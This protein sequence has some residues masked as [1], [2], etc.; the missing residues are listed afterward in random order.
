M[1]A[2]ILGLGLFASVGAHAADLAVRAVPVPL[3]LFSWT[4]FYVG[5]Q[6]G[7]ATLRDRLVETDVCVP[8]CIDSATGNPSGVIGGAHA[9]FNWQSGAIV[10][11]IEADIEG[12]SLSHTTIY[13][14]S[15]PDT[16]GSSIP[17][18]GS[19]RGRIGYAFNQVLIYATGGAAIAD[20][21]H[22]YFEAV[23]GATQTLSTTR[24]GWTIGGGIEYSLAQHWSARVEYRYSDFG[25]RTDA[26]A[27]VFPARFRENHSETENAVRIGVSYHF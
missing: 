26:P 15:A 17:V 11:G 14:L 2:V 5:G 25:H 24:T 23:A 9:G 10:F 22:R 20:I 1:R 4:G 16:F 27:I 21:E 7:G 12:A 3:P 13:P 19:V 8:A 18:Q 6:I